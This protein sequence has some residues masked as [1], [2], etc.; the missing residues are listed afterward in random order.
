M[1]V[2]KDAPPIGLYY[3]GVKGAKVGEVHPDPTH[4]PILGMKLAEKLKE[5]GVE[6]EFQSSG[7]PNAK[8]PTPQ[9]FLIEHLKK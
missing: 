9:A 3:G 7:E 6:V 4:S 2:T 1:H 5:K 8:Y